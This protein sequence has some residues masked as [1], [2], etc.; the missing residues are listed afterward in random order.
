MDAGQKAG[1][2]GRARPF[3][4]FPRGSLTTLLVAFSA[5]LA[6]AQAPAATGAGS[7]EFVA[8]V[9]IPEVSFLNAQTLLSGSSSDGKERLEVKLSGRDLIVLRDVQPCL[10]LSGRFAGVLPPGAPHRISVRWNKSSAAVSLDGRK[11]EALEPTRVDRFPTFAVARWEAQSR[12]VE[13]RDL[14]VDKLPVLPELQSDQRFVARMTCF[15]PGSTIKEAVVETYR[16]V[17]IRGASDPALRA[18]LKQW[19]AAMTPAMGDA[20]KTVALTRDGSETWRGLALVD[21]RAILL[22][23]ESLRNPAVFFHEGAHL[24]D[25]A[26]RWRDSL[27]W[28]ERFMGLPAGTRSFS[29]GALGH[30]DA[31]APAEQL[32]EFV[33]QARA[34]TLGFAQARLCTGDL[35]CGEK[36][37]L[38]AGRGYVSE[39]DAKRLA[40]RQTT[41]AAAAGSASNGRS[42]AAPVHNPPQ[43]NPKYKTDLIVPAADA[44]RIDIVLDA[45]HFRPIDIYYDGGTTVPPTWRGC[46][47]EDVMNRLSKKRPAAIV[48]EPQLKGVSRVYGYFDLG[49]VKAKR[50]WFALDEFADGKIEMLLDMHANGRL[51][52]A[53]PLPNM[54]QFKDGGK[55][56]ATLIEFPWTAV[57]DNPP[58]SGYFKLWFMSNPF[59][60]AIAGFSKSS[61]TQLIGAIQL[62]GERYDLVVAD[63]AYSDNDGDLTNDGICLRKPGQRPTCHKDAEARAG[64]EIAGRR[65]AFNIIGR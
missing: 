39:I 25:G 20:V 21:S 1:G 37:Q 55:G 32:A 17:D 43:P 12:E 33:A 30:M 18:T 7:V 45:K 50:H 56:Y 62:A 19:I 53:P 10:R 29:P 65:Y 36:L 42:K 64:I 59:E 47:A 5:Q 60:W 40:D 9:K 63:S 38:L 6:W 57:M 22:R 51:D 26:H 41:L 31:G 48:S 54:G 14:A 35:R 3:D 24:L 11:E 23:P 61:H 4:G 44:T 2:I 58:W 27:E 13:V 15:D 28:G 46:K 49:T 16:G 52:E 34:E 8:A